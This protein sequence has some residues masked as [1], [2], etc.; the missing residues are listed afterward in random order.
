MVQRKGV[1]D[2]QNSNR[3]IKYN[4]KETRVMSNL[5]P[6]VANVYNVVLMKTRGAEEGEEEVYKVR[7]V[8]AT[9]LQKNISL[10]LNNR[11]E[12]KDRF[13]AGDFDDV[14]Y[15]IETPGVSGK[16]AKTVQCVLHREL[17]RFAFDEADFEEV[18]VEVEKLVM[19]IENTGKNALAELA[20]AKKKED[21]LRKG[22]YIPIA[23]LGNDLN[24][25]YKGCGCPMCTGVKYPLNKSKD[26]AK[27][28]KNKDTNVPRNAARSAFSLSTFA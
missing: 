10:D 5:E 24:P 26:K 9:M 2:G 6:N 4:Y 15:I 16:H 17:H 3:T 19:W 8:S 22:R 12:W 27:G 23:K 28:S 11:W 21:S 18:D 20:D 25:K 14:D 1:K 13:I 7:L